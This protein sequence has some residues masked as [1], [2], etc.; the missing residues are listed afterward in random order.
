[1]LFG[2]LRRPAPKV[3][4]KNEIHKAEDADEMEEIEVEEEPIGVSKPVVKTEKIQPTRTFRPSPK[5]QKVNVKPS[6][7]V[8]NPYVEKN[9]KIQNVIY[10]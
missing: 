8:M 9:G 2:S 1:M 10:I 7:K 5:K 3:M 6:K 4:V